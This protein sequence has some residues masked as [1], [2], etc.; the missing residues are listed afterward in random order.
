M[1]VKIYSGFLDLY[2]IIKCRQDCPPGYEVLDD[3]TC[4]LPNECP[5][6]Y[7]PGKVRRISSDHQQ[8]QDAT[9]TRL[10][11]LQDYSFCYFPASQTYGIHWDCY[12][13]D[14]RTADWWGFR[15]A[16]HPYSTPPKPRPSRIT[17]YGFCPQGAPLPPEPACAI[18][19]GRALL[20]MQV[21]TRLPEASAPTPAPLTR[22]T[23][24]MTTTT[25][26]RPAT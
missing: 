13:H 6:G 20:L 9:Q 1:Q 14:D 7:D 3:S 4:R 22:L 15:C 24:G 25:A 10:C 23:R 8:C 2:S 21:G 5:G 19:L 16:R 17:I 18:M 11:R 26:G 12:K